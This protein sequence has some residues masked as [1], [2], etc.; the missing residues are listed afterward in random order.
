VTTYKGVNW[1]VVEGF[2]DFYP[3]EIKQGN[4]V[5]GEKYKHKGFVAVQASK[6][7]P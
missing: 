4:E 7:G 1:Q 3:K 2:Y 5:Y 6:L